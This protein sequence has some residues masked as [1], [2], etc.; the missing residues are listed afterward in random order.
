MLPHHYLGKLCPKGHDHEG[1]GKSLRNRSGRACLGCVRECQRRRREDPAVRARDAAYLREWARRN[2]KKCSRR[3][4]AFKATHENYRIA[5][6][7]R[8]RL[9]VAFKVAGVQKQRASKYGV[10]WSAIVAHLGPQPSPEHEIDHIRPLA[11]FDLTDPAQVREACRPE[12]HRWLLA[13]ENRSKGSR[14]DV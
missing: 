1:T 3:V 7:L 4:M 2:S 5:S 12:N 6:R 14:I 9:L 8:N 11:S 10:D 13:S